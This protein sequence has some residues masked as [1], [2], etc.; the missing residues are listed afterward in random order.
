MIKRAIAVA[1][2]IAGMAAVPP[3]L[4]ADDTVGTVDRAP[5]SA[6]ERFFYR[7]WSSIRSVTP[8][9][10]VTNDN[11][12]VVATAGLRGAEG[13]SDAMAPYWKGDLTADPKF[14]ARVESYRQA[15]ARGEQGHPDGLQNY[16]DEYGDSDLA[17]NARF[18]LAVVHA[19]AN[20]PEE[21]RR[22]L[23][24]FMSQNPAHPLM[25]QARA[26]QQRL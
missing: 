12:R 6:V 25:P 4:A 7:V 21:A 9:A 8:Q 20:R 18:A 13:D 19:R 10:A 16:L 15:I 22:T 26:L 14:R 23:N 11:S 1:I 24:V 2:A 3:G 5:D 17:A